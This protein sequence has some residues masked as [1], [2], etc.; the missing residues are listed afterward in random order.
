MFSA[1]DQDSEQF[2]RAIDAGAAGFVVR[3][4]EGDRLIDKVRLAAERGRRLRP[5]L[6]PAESGESATPPEPAGQIV[7]FYIARGGSGCT[8]LATN[9]AVVLQTEHTPAV[10][11]DAH[12]Q[13]GDAEAFL[14][15]TGRVTLEDLAAE[16]EQLDEETL[17][18]ML[19][20]HASGLRV[21]PAPAS[22]EGG[23]EVTAEALRR[24]LDLLRSRFAYI[25]VDLPSHLD[26]AT[27]TVLLM[28]SLVVVVM[29]P[30]IPCVKNTHVFLH[31]MADEGIPAERMELVLNQVEKRG[32]VKGD[33][34]AKSVARPCSHR[35]PVRE[36]SCVGLDQS[37]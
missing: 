17:Q 20:V 10:L 15:L 9:V 1:L 21:L 4:I 13:Y 36:R 29:V 25:V 19:A 16:A 24:L 22:P 11:V 8:A 7:A 5:A 33:Q 35:D 23:M 6:T 28:A 31:S 18:E 37:R 14:N 12:L 26:Q 30:D 2:E 34:V 27:L 32:G 3:P